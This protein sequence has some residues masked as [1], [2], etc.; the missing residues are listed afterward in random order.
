MGCN[1][2]LTLTEHEQSRASRSQQTETLSTERRAQIRNAMHR[3]MAGPL[4]KILSDPSHRAHASAAALLVK[5]VQSPRDPMPQDEQRLAVEAF[6]RIVEDHPDALGLFE[7]A[8]KYGPG[9]SPLSHPYELFAAAALATRCCASSSNR[10]FTI[11]QTDRLDFGIKLA[12]SYGQPKRFGTIEAD[13]MVQRPK[14]LVDTTV[15]ALDTKFSRTGR[16]S[17]VDGLQ[18][19]LDGIRTG[20]RD[21]KVD[22]FFFV[23]NGIF[24]QPFKDLVAAENIR[25]ARDFYTQAAYRMRGVDR[26]LLTAEEAVTTPDEK[27][28]ASFFKPENAARV[29]EFVQKY[30][31]V[32]VELFEHV[33]FNGT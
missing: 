9:A 28:G 14:H 1:R 33:R 8:A 17:T 27:L 25:I 11:R 32:Q 22:D 3:A 13:I 30:N 15:I 21:G 7:A 20:L 16:Y 5:A 19:Q 18:R 29:Q 4:V 12:K 2:G 26:S 31:V 10:E 6:V 23:T 24:A